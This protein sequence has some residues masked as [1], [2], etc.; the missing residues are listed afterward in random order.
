MTMLWVLFM[1]LLLVTILVLVLPFL[2]S[3]RE[4][5]PARADYDMVV[6]RSQLQEIDSEIE[7]GLLTT[8][9]ADAARAEVH[10]RMLD[11]ED[12]ELG[13]SA[14]SN[15]R[16][17]FRLAAVIGVAAIL[18]LGAT[19]MYGM[20]GSPNLPGKPYAW[21]TTHDPEFVSASSA[22][23]LER[24]LQDS[25]T[26]AGFKKLAGMYFEARDFEKAAE[27]DRR[28]IAMGASDPAT[29]SEFGESVVMANGGAVVPEA[30]M[31][32]TNA[33]TA[34][35]KNVRARFYIGLAESQIGNLKQAVAVWR[36]LEK[37]AD[38]NEA[39]RPLVDA[40]IQ[41]VAK[42]GGFDAASVPPQAPSVE[43]LNVALK[44]MTSAMRIHND[45]SGAPAAPAAAPPSATA[46]D[47]QTMVRAM[48]ECF[49]AKVEANPNDAAGW[50]K[51]VRY[52]VVLGEQEKARKAAERAVKLKPDDPEN[53]QALYVIGQAEA[54]AGRPGQAKT[55]WSKALKLASD[56]DP[57]KPEIRNALAGLGTR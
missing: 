7:R 25:P 9:E 8:A 36:D 43:A 28:A 51:L 2:R 16:R 42:Q 30:M 6:Y 31:A 27:A 4:E 10:R 44:A 53:V 24:L 54:Q 12:A 55:V 26:A 45:V 22:Q 32:F 5:P 47:Q 38:P 49:A 46:N 50:Q 56:G 39:W 1:A 41:N 17:S 20:L 3:N 23:S 14:A 52:Y 19:A 13:R 21:R 34:D 18:P 29:W 37:D 40:N 15:S 35:R 57:L 48:V 33:L 11:A